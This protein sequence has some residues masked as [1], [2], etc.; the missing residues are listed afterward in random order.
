MSFVIVKDSARAGWTMQGD[1]EKIFG[2]TPRIVFASLTAFWAGEFAEFICPCKNEVV[3]ERAY[4][5]VQNHRIDNC[6]RGG[7]F[8]VFYPLAF[9]GAEGWSMTLMLTVM[10]SN[11]LMK[12]LWEVLATPFTYR[13]VN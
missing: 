3:Y 10:G 9:L 7:R 13:V 8:N 4:A 12:V 1:Y 2:A 6:R 5:V 11:C